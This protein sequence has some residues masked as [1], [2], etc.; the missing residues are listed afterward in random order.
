M[1]R[2]FWLLVSLIFGFSV[3][4]LLYRRSELVAAALPLMV[5]LLGAIW[6]IPGQ[7][8]LEAERRLST[9][10]ASE[11]IPLEVRVKVQNQGEMVDEFYLVDRL[12]PG[13]EVV[14]GDLIHIELFPPEGAIE[15]HYRLT[16]KRGRYTLDGLL[17]TGM[18][19]FGLFRVESLLS[20]LSTLLIYPVSEDLPSI[21][22]RPPNTKG[23][24]G[25]IP[26]RKSGVGMDFFG[27]RAYQP[28]DPLRRI[29]WRLTARHLQDL[30]AN[31]FEQERIADIGL[32]LDA[33]QQYNYQCGA[34][35]IFEYS[36]LACASLASAFLADGHSVSLVMFGAGISRVFPGY[37]KVQR[38]RILRALAN[39]HTGFNFALESL[40]NLPAR[41]LAP[42]GQLVYISTVSP[43]DIGPLLR[44]RAQGYEVIV[45]SPDPLSFELKGEAPFFSLEDRLAERFARLERDLLLRELRS[46][47]IL[48]AV[49]DVD[50]PL[51][52]AVDSIRLQLPLRRRVV[53]VL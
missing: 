38:E 46:A 50:Q 9:D 6:R 43:D 49:W 41:L 33:R 13:I 39:A 8:R 24:S 32:I 34:R 31:E 11:G 15:L 2:S 3:L 10:K 51:S 29:N 47:G 16:G 44:F 52:S 25:P 35:Q 23:F 30:Y 4:G 28:G 20:P 5:Y 18:D 17:A 53:K 37:G 36:V 40:G 27:V 14:E 1:T 19:P 22:I 21:P 12:P 42:H 7:F 26:S 48:V 45:V